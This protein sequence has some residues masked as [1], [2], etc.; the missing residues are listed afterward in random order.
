M[1]S[2]FFSGRLGAGE[3]R[4]APPRSHDD[5]TQPRRQSLGFCTGGAVEISQRQTPFTS[6]ESTGESARHFVDGKSHHLGGR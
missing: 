6:R 3:Y 1:R 4:D 5:K 2:P